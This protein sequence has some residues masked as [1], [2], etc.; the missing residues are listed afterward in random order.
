MICVPE[1]LTVINSAFMRQRRNKCTDRSHAGDTDEQ[2][3]TRAP[4]IR[5]RSGLFTGDREL[6]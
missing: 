2:I 1:S 4:A 6:A 3:L 5:R